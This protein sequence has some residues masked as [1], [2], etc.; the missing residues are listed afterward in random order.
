MDQGCLPGRDRT[1][2]SLARGGGAVRAPRAARGRRARQP[3]R[4][5]EH[6]RAPRRAARD[7]ALGHGRAPARARRGLRRR[8]P[9]GRADAGHG[10]PAN[11]RGDQPARKRGASSDYF[12]DRGVA[13]QRRRGERLRARR[14]RFSAQA[15]RSG[16]S[17]LKGVGLRRP[18]PERADD[19]NGRPGSC[20]SANAKH[21]S[22]A[23]S[24]ASAP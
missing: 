15:V 17:A 20:A 23:A 21:S 5:R 3:H 22:G 10:R 19:Q 8:H 6:P 13:G 9:H 12:S 16:N 11:R 18:V 1:G 14:R 4:A 24:C 2:G 7:R